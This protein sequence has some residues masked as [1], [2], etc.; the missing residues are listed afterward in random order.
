MARKFDLAAELNYLQVGEKLMSLL[1]KHLLFS[2]LSKYSNVQMYCFAL[3]R[4]KY[5]QNGLI[6]GQ[7]MTCGKK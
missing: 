6:D 3:T 2:H 1:Y 5:L 4:N 7:K